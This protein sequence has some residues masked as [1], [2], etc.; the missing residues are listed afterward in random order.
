MYHY[1][2]GACVLFSLYALM[3]HMQLGIP[4]NLLGLPPLSGFAYDAGNGLCF[5]GIRIKCNKEPSPIIVVTEPEDFTRVCVMTNRMQL[6]PVFV[7]KYGV[8]SHTCNSCP[9]QVNCG[10]YMKYDFPYKELNQYDYREIQNAKKLVA[11]RYI[12]EH[13]EDFLDEML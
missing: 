12:L 13:P 1:A 2:Y 8:C 9:M 7:A 4:H 5:D 11:T 3:S 10:A 6:D